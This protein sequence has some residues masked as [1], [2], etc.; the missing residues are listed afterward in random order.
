M[1]STGNPDVDRVIAVKGEPISTVVRD[2]VIDEVMGG[3]STGRKI[4]NPAPTRRLTFAD[5]TYIDVK[6]EAMPGPVGSD[7]SSV[8]LPEQVVGG[9]ALKDVAQ[10]GQGPTAAQA[11]TARHNRATEAAAANAAARQARTEARQ[12]RTAER[13]ADLADRRE[14]RLITSQE[15]QAK[16]AALREERANNIA[17]R[18][19]SIDEADRLYDRRYRDEVET[20]LK[21]AAEQ[22]AVEAAKRQEEQ[23][24]FERRKY[25]EQQVTAREKETTRRREAGLEY[26]YRAGQDAVSNALKLLPYR[27]G[28]AFA[29]EY[30]AALGVLSGGG[31]PVSF[32]PGAFEFQEPDLTALA[33]QAAQRAAQQFSATGMS[34]AFSPGQPAPPPVAPPVP[35]APPTGAPAADP[36]AGVP[37]APRVTGGQVAAGSVGG[38]PSQEELARRLAAGYGA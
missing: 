34:A 16:A 6:T 2:P 18:K 21:R 22:R 37:M 29:S 11:E 27:A 3:S 17:E 31:G 4:P 19:M 26:G 28:P 9:T 12:T 38:N 5:G 25:E 30:A 13:S 15:A 32:S 36:L 1:A 8:A 35:P 24:A 7:A 14:D 33:D 10:Q 23:A 20:P